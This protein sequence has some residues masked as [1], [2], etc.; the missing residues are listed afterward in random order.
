MSSNAKIK[1][2]SIVFL[3]AGILKTAKQEFGVDKALIFFSSWSLI[4]VR[5]EA[6]TV[7][8]S[9][10]VVYKCSNSKLDCS[11]S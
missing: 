6:F 10:N 1:P 5:F 2:E 11:N 3:G 4:R 8:K 9:F 7:S